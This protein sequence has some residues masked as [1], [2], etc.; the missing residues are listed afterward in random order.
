[1]RR[2]SARGPRSA[3]RCSGSAARRSSPSASRRCA[4][5]RPAP[6]RADGVRQRRRLA[7]VPVAHSSASPG[8]E[9]QRAGQ[10]LEARHAERV[11]VRAPVDVAA[12]APRLLRRDVRERPLELRGQLG[13]LPLERQLG[14]EP[15]VG[16]AAAPTSMGSTRMLRGVTSLCTTSRSCSAPRMRARRMASGKK[17][18][19]RQRLARTLGRAVRRAASRTTPSRARGSPSRAARARAPSRSPAST[20]AAARRTRAAARRDRAR[21]DTARAPS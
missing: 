17:Q 6:R 4:R 7:D 1:M 11:V 3:R 12:R 15:E 5:A 19:E 2:G 13:A 16:R 10:Q 14:A 21:A 8:V 20:A 9:R 18:R